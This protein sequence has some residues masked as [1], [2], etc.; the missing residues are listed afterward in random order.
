MGS[1]WSQEKAQGDP[2]KTRHTDCDGD[3]GTCGR[4]ARFRLIR[5]G[6]GKKRVILC[7]KCLKEEQQFPEWIYKVEKLETLT[8]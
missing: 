3:G 4:T 6:R 2:L 5:K 7:P 1:S 8:S